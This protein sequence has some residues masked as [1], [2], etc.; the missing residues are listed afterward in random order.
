[1]RWKRNGSLAPNIFGAERKGAGALYNF[2]RD[3]MMVSFK[4]QWDGSNHNLIFDI[5]IF[6][7][8]IF[9]N[10]CSRT[11]FTNFVIK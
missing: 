9:S 1:M 2:S 5:A 10:A 11:L 7:S 6:I 4:F 8:Y 3:N